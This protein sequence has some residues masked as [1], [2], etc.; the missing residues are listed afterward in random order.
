[1]SAQ[2]NIDRIILDKIGNEGF[3]IEAGGS[4][5]YDQNNSNL[6]E[7]QGWKGLIVEPKHDWN[8]IYQNNRPNSILEN[9]V[10][11]SFDHEGSTIRGDFNRYMMGGVVN[12]FNFP[13]WSPSDYSCTTLDNLLKKHSIEEVTCFY[14]DVE[15]YEI[16]VLNGTD[17]DRVFFHVL[18]IEN[19]YQKG[20]KDDFNFLNKY[21]FYQKL[22][23]N[24]HEFYVNE[25]S[26]F[27]DNFSK[28]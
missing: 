27:Y 8:L 23:I 15:G 24:Q 5:P 19:H 4:H 16:E 25:K 21:G 1:M 13:D 2:N 26:P 10:L 3:F 9:T 18:V 28:E 20:Y 7:D 11:V 6:L 12:T 14:L 22:V 17:F